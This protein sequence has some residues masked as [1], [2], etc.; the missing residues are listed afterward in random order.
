[1][2]SGVLDVFG[3]GMDLL[4]PALLALATFG[5][6]RA[7]RVAAT[8]PGVAF[9]AVFLGLLWVGYAVLL[10]WMGGFPIPLF[11]QNAAIVWPQLIFFGHTLWSVEPNGG[12]AFPH[13]WAGLVTVGFWSVVGVVFVAV[14][15]RVR[16]LPLLAGLAVIVVMVAYASVKAAVPLMHWRFLLEFP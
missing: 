4:N 11:F 10:G 16:S 8:R 14:L 3:D 7:A 6:V 13:A 2:V 12:P 5:S 1:M 9:I 15:R